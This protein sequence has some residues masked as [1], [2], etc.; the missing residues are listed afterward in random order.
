MARAARVALEGHGAVEGPL[1]VCI[2][3][4][5]GTPKKDRH[6]K[7]HTHRPDA[8]NLAKLALDA[9]MKAG[10]IGDDSAVATL[11]VR[12]TWDHEPGMVMT[13]APDIR[14][15]LPDGTPDDDRPG[16]APDWLN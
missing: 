9:V 12:K 10:L 6:G 15:D 5:F 7:P 3:F 13:I 4:S 2:G 16:Q 11:V 8:D 1:A 14:L